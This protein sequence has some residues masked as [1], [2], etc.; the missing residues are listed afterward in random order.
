MKNAPQGTTNRTST[1]ARLARGTVAAIAV[2]ALAACSPGAT[3]PPADGGTGLSGEVV[4]ADFGGPTHDARQTAFFDSFGETGASVVSTTLE[5]SIKF[6]MLEGG[7]GAYDLIQVSANNVYPNVDTLISLPD[8]FEGN[9]LMN[10]DMRKYAVGGF[11]FAVQQG[12]LTDTYSNG[13]PK[14]WDDFFDLEK[15]PGKRAWPGTPAGADASYEIALLADGVAVEDLYPLDIERAQAK[16]DTIKD[17]LIFYTSYAETQTLLASGTAAIAVSVSGQFTTLRNGGLDVTTQWNQAFPS[18]G[19]FV[20]PEKAPNPENAL[21]LAS[22][23]AEPKNEAE[24]VKITGYGPANSKTL[25]S[26]SQEILKNL[27]NTEEHLK[28]AV[29]RDEMYLADHLVEMTQGY[30]EWLTR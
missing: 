24:F 16:L 9:D 21:A 15:F 27:P 12:W 18:P 5:N 20:I 22:W 26:L 8:D 1:L 25:A 10:E 19:F 2:L 14:D 23:M 6:S 13:G 4:F 29:F 11:V 28:M 17:Q 3:T 7:E 30:S